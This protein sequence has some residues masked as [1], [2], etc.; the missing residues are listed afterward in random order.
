MLTSV[1][2]NGNAPA[3]GTEVFQGNAGLAAVTRLDGAAGWGAFWGGTRVV[4]RLVRATASVKPTVS[5]TASVN[6]ILTSPKG[7]WTGYPAPNF[8]YQW[9]ACTAA[10]TAP[11]ATV[12]ATCKKITGATKSTFKLTTAQR[13]KYVTVLVTGTSSGTTP[14]TWLAKTT[15]KVK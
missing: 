8:T 15:T 6:K 7:S 10:V 2:F 12:P 14:T 11:R 13:N 4:F 9:Y 3:A 5:G 1:I